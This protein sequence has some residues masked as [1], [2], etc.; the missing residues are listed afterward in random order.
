MRKETW[1]R[2]L[3]V[4]DGGQVSVIS[5]DDVSWNIIN[6]DSIES[7]DDEWTGQEVEELKEWGSGLKI[8]WAIE[9]LKEHVQNQEDDE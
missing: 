2:V 9:Q 7:G 5:D 3:V 1:K 6:W 4:L 8:D